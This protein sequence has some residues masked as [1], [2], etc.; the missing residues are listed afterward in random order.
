VGLGLRRRQREGNAGIHPGHLQ[1]RRW[2][3][4]CPVRRWMGSVSEEQ[5]LQAARAYVGIAL[6]AVGSVCVRIDRI[7]CIAVRRGGS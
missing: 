2:I 4:V 6:D 7:Y 1:R 5:K 3:V